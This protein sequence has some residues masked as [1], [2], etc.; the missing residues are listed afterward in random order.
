MLDQRCHSEISGKIFSSSFT[1]PISKMVNPIHSQNNPPN[2]VDFQ[3]VKQGVPKLS[4]LVP[5]P[6]GYWETVTDRAP[7]NLKAEQ[8]DVLFLQLFSKSEINQS[9]F[10]TSAAVQWLGRH[11]SA[12]GVTGSILLGNE[13][14]TCYRVRL[15]TNTFP[16][17]PKLDKHRVKTDNLSYLLSFLLSSILLSRAA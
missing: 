2:S 11:T 14:P 13:D 1:T 5:R 9:F 6:W 16:P 4:T 8:T 15:K 10:Q 3:K 17:H 12:A 7:G